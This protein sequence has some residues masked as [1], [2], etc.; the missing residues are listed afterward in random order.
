M[1]FPASKSRWI[2]RAGY[3]ALAWMVSSIKKQ[4]SSNLY[5]FGVHELIQDRTGECCWTQ[6]RSYFGCK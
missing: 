1:N 6:V 3:S 5:H 4:L 2:L